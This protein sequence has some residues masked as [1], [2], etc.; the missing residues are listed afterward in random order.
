MIH[1]EDKALS[2]ELLILSVAVYQ[3]PVAF[4]Q[5][6]QAGCKKQLEKEFD[7]DLCDVPRSSQ[8]LQKEIPWGPFSSPSQVARHYLPVQVPV[9]GSYPGWYV[10]R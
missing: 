5:A 10:E 4:R 9:R 8:L 2:D 3:S 7:E 1:P 6:K